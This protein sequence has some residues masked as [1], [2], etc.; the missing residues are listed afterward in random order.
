M[1]HPLLAALVI[2][3]ATC[4]LARPLQA[5]TGVD[6]LQQLRTWTAGMQQ[7]A[8]HLEDLLAIERL[9]RAYGYYIDKG[10]WHEAAD[11]FAADATLEIGVDGVY[12][13]QDRIRQM[14]AAY[15]GGNLKTGPGL[16]FGQLN[17]HMQ[18]QP[19]VSIAEDGRHAAARWREFSLL[20]QYEV[21]AAWGD[22]VME[23][24]Y[25]KEAGVWK[26]A[27]LHVYTNFI[28]PY[29]GGWAK[30][31]ASPTDWRSEVAKA[32]PADAPPS[33][34]YSPFPAVYTPPYHYD[35][36][37]SLSNT[38]W[39]AVISAVQLTGRAGELQ[40]ALLPRAH[41][42]DAL[43]AERD[44]ENLQAIYGYYIDKGRWT[45]A[46]QLFTADASYEFGQNGVYHGS[47]RIKQA[48]SLMGP[49]G[50][51]R[52]MLN[53]YP[54][55]QPIITV[56]P[57]NLTAKARWRSDVQLSTDGEGVWG[58]GV[59]ENEYRLVD[60]QWRISKLHYYV[61]FWAEY[62]K[63]WVDGTF[64][65][66]AA[67]TALPPDAPPTEVYGSQP[68]VYLF[69]FSYPHLVK[70]GPHMGNLEATA[71]SKGNE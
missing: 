23:N 57:D 58:G 61:T 43:R 13:G 50:L 71:G 64:P 49:E 5:Q 14:L 25:V 27:S 36:A 32:N 15:G 30:L 69:P 2:T 3:I 42:L 35:G 40:Q 34:N 21:S 45:Q 24:T 39:E 10:Y 65:M 6:Q 53:N 28:A 70:Q 4:L 38:H 18:L 16:P 47:E 55:L 68:A 19:V 52:G 31:S 41:Q 62:D 1:K 37:F 12:Q 20:G 51:A 22:A 48:L 66:A 33:V 11:L 17:M 60:G 7:D 9:Q 8:L 26:L 29:A 46:A 67:S 54:M 63:G 44:I 56:A 59:Y